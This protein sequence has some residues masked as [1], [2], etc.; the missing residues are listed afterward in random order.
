MIRVLIVD[1]HPI[2][3]RGLCDLVSDAP[4][5]TVVAEVDDGLRAMTVAR[6]VAWDVALLDVSMPRLNGVELL[7]RLARQFPERKILMLSQFPESQF[8]TRVMR[9]GA[10]GYLSKSGP[11][12]LVIEAIRRV[13]AGRPVP[14]ALHPEGELDAAPRDRLPHE[15]LSAREYQVFT[16][17][18]G[19]RSVTE[20][21]AELNVAVSTVSNHLV[22]VKTK[23]G[24]STLGGVVAYAHRVGLAE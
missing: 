6:D 13:A 1:D 12:D 11:P 7:R 23:L 19:G 17:I 3:R 5:M 15:A 20:A 4:D 21:A 24:V 10:Q 22:Q 14:R 16:L 2:F 9:E 8:A 18:V